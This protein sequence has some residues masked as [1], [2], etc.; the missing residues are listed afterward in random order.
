MNKCASRNDTACGIGDITEELADDDHVKACKNSDVKAEQAKEAGPKEEVPRDIVREYVLQ[1]EEK[2]AKRRSKLPLKFR[3]LKPV[4]VAKNRAKL[5][6]SM[7][8]R[9]Q[10][11]WR[12]RSWSTDK[13]LDH[14]KGK[15]SEGQQ[16][17]G[18]MGRHSMERLPTLS[19]FDEERIMWIKNLENDICMEEERRARSQLRR[20]QTT[21]SDSSSSQSSPSTCISR[22]TS[23]Y[24]RLKKLMKPLVQPIVAAAP[25]AAQLDKIQHEL[26]VQIPSVPDEVKVETTEPIEATDE[27]VESKETEVFV[28]NSLPQEVTK[29]EPKE[30]QPQE[31]SGEVIA[32]PQADTTT[33][34][35]SAE[36]QAK[37]RQLRRSLKK[38]ERE[39]AM[40]RRRSKSRKKYPPLSAECFLVSRGWQ[41]DQ[42][43]LLRALDRLK[44]A[45]FGRVQ[46]ATTMNR[47]VE[48]IRPHLDAV[49][50]HIGNQELI[51]AAYSVVSVAQTG[52]NV[53]DSAAI[54]LS[55]AGSVATVMSRHI[56]T[57]A[58]Q[59]RATQFIISLPLP[60]S[61]A[62]TN[63]EADI[64]YTELRRMFNATMK[65]NC[66]TCPNVQTCENEN[67]A[68][69][70]P[71]L[72]PSVLRKSESDDLQAPNC[73]PIK[74]PNLSALESGKTDDKYILDNHQLT[75]AGMRKLARNWDNCLGR[76]DRASDGQLMLRRSSDSSETSTSGNSGSGEQH[77][78]VFGRVEAAATNIISD[79]SIERPSS[80]KQRSGSA[81]SSG[82]HS[83]DSLE[84]RAPWKPC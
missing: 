81:S 39:A 5:N 79:D 67:L 53:R 11:L 27:N 66:T 40:E 8:E 36:D 84:Q 54:G 25:G 31:T 33:S 55:V 71:S 19:A 14:K 56:I 4:S 43:R 22:G 73:T 35:S 51:E 82:S 45:N 7:Q 3:D 47:V 10:K 46:L 49:I 38:K 26:S 21:T 17:L 74:K 42:T 29:E 62:K 15:G 12:T 23:P 69:N 32:E 41:L 44:V 18:T 2:I 77:V 9:K 75:A 61:L 83:A 6:T 59:N 48:S 52:E 68:S 70:N 34:A 63:F 60:V 13:L 58:N 78:N 37:K 24:N 30:P 72:P 80:D 28:E 65:A 64:H 57:A 16:K 76:I 20:A 50:I 1:E